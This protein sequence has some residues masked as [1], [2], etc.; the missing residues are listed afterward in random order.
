MQLIINKIAYRQLPL[1]RVAVA[2]RRLYNPVLSGVLGVCLLAG[3]CACQTATPRVGAVWESQRLHV[4]RNGDEA[5]FQSGH[6]TSIGPARQ[7]LPPEQQGAEFYVSWSGSEIELVKF[8]YRQVG[9]PDKI[10]TQQFTPGSARSHVFLVVGE[11]RR[12]G[13]T[14]SGWRVSLWH[15][16]QLLAEKKSSLW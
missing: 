16:E 2:G 15:G 1:G 13:G 3:L 6:A 5:L 7:I 8:E 11:E 9:R 4:V 14:V 12:Q 10:A